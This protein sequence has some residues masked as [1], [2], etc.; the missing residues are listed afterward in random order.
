MNVSHNEGANRNTEI[1]MLRGIGMISVLLIHSTVHYLS[2]PLAYFLWDTNQFAVQLLV[3][4]SAYVFFIKENTT[5]LMSFTYFKKRIIRLLKPYYIFLM[6]FL[7]CLFLFDKNTLTFPFVYQ[8]LLVFGGVD[9][10]WLVL[11]FLQF[12]VAFPLLEYLKK[13]SPI[14][15][16]TIA[17]GSIIYSISLLFIKFPGNYKIIMWLPWLVIV[18]YSLLYKKFQ[19]NMKFLVL[20]ILVCAMLFIELFMLLA[21]LGHSVQLYDNKYPP[22][23]FFVTYGVGMIAV[24][25]LLNRAHLFKMLKLHPLL[26]FFSVNSFSIF[27]I[28]YIIIYF[29]LKLSFYPKLQWYGFF[30]IVLFSSFIFQYILNRSLKILKNNTN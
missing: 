15:F 18:F 30:S 13:K 25:I 4:C 22:N 5:S 19:Q 9:I 24:F 11:L 8:S 28:H 16:T 1:D 10:N 14:A 23:F 3:F 6:V 17:V 27:F 26:K 2:D 20:T 29:L 21:N 12:T 7:A